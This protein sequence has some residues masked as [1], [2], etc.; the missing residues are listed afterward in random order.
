MGK[1]VTLIGLGLIASSIAH[2]LNELRS[3]IELFG[4]DI[5]KEVRKTAKK[6][7]IINVSDDIESVVKNSDLTIMCTPVGVI[8]SVVEQ[9]SPF[10]KNGSILSDVGSVKKSVVKSVLPKL[11]RRAHFVI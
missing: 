2:S 9:I 4:Y 6:L 1:K 11:P 5:S 7:G 3:D 8:G 10:L